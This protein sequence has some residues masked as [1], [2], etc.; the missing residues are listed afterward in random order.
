[1]AYWI[2]V[3]I[4]TVVQKPSSM[5]NKTVKRPFETNVEYIDENSSFD[6]VA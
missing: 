6:I 5:K 1:M 2:F 4:G 3:E